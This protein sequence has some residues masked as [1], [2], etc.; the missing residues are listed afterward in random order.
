M[1]AAVSFT[2]VQG[3]RWRRTVPGDVAVIGQVEG[4]EPYNT[5]DTRRNLGGCVP[6]LP[7]NLE[8]SP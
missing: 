5:G 8:L 1:T 3:Q 7:P 2:D 6:R 4:R